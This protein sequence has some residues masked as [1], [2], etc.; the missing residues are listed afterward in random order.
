[1]GILIGTHVFTLERA[2]DAWNA[3]PKV[4]TTGTSLPAPVLKA[5]S[6]EF[7]GVVSDYLF[8]KALVFMGSKIPRAGQRFSLTPDE[9][10]WFDNLLTVSVSLDPYFV[11]PYY[12]GN[13]YLTW[14]AGMVKEANALLEKGAQ[15]RTWDWTIPFF[16][17]FNYFYFLQEND[18]A[19]EYLMQASRTPGASPILASLAS[20]LAFK[21]KR[22]ESSIEFLEEMIKK[23][24][25][26]SLRKLFETRVQAF[27]AILALEKAVET[28]R[29]KF[30]KT[31]DH[32]DELIKKGIIAEI[33]KDPY[34]GK[35][36]LAEEG[37]VKSTTI[38]MLMPHEP[39]H[40]VR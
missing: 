9:W 31:P 27:Q 6:L 32:L 35:F 10:A 23:T 36:F 4:E 28:Y 2:T 26:E 20:K 3:L 29:G 13:A 40:R 37:A 38:H 30:G 16:I 15:Y 34:G 18:K 24:D 19:G 33:P 21:A 25:D 7:D 39:Q 5:V 14:D 11:D 12:I 17:G 1:M 8:L 22:T